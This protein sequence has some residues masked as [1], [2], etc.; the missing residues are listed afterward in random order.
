MTQQMTTQQPVNITEQLQQVEQNIR[1]YENA[2]TAVKTRVE[3]Y[4]QQ[5]AQIGAEIQ[6]M[7]VNPQTIEEELKTLAQTILTQSKQLADLLPAELIEQLQQDLNRPVQ[8]T[9]DLPDFGITF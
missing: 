3:G 1:K 2:T 7:G 8:A 6:S 5:Y 9:V 4:R